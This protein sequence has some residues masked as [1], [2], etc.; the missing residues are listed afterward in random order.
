[1]EIHPLQNDQ[2]EAL[3]GHITRHLADLDDQTLLSLADLTREATLDTETVS[4]AG[5]PVSRR[6]FLTAT[7]AGGFVAATAGYCGMAIRLWARPGIERR[8]G[9]LER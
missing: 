8:P 6:R 4:V 5:S 2:R 7:L 1:M 9:T 3:I